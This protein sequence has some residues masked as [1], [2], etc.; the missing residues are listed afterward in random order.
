M[1]VEAQHVSNFVATEALAQNAGRR[2]LDMLLFSAQVGAQEGEPP[3]PEGAVLAQ[4]E[5][6]TAILEGHVG[7][8]EGLRQ[9]ILRAVGVERA[10]VGES[11]KKRRVECVAG[12]FGASRT[13]RAVGVVLVLHQSES[14]PQVAAEH[15]RIEE[16]KTFVADGHALLHAAARGIDSRAAVA[17]ARLLAVGSV[18]RVQRS[19]PAAQVQVG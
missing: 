16:G 11:G 8:A 4:T 18:G 19:S 7:A 10:V 1:A 9:K 2:L 13:Y 5:R 3:V 6:G 12:E 15:A 17:G 14:Q